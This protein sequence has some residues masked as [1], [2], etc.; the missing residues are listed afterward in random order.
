MR[1]FG[2][3]VFLFLSFSCSPENDGE[4]DSKAEFALAAVEDNIL[5][6]DYTALVEIIKV[7]V[8]GIAEDST[9]KNDEALVTVKYTARILE[10]YLGQE[11]KTIEFREYVEKSE[12]LSGLSRGV[13]I[14]SLCKDKA[15]NY[16]LPDIGYELPAQ[17]VILERAKKIKRQIKDK[18]LTLHKDDASYAC[19]PHL[20]GPE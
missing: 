17:N 18:K 9:A 5:T 19:V 10:S 20:I 8:E 6:T 7:N 2:L 16:Y 4:E 13:L 3:V 15:D 11:Q 14:V 12:G 1:L